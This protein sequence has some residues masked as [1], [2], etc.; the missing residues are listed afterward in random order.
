MVL[1]L[2]EMMETVVSRF[3]Q[4]SISN[5]ELA[6]PEPQSEPSEH[7]PDPGLPAYAIDTSV[8]LTE[9]C[10][11]CAQFALAVPAHV[12]LAVSL[13]RQPHHTNP[14]QGL[15][16]GNRCNNAVFQSEVP[17]HFLNVTT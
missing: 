8:F 3:D 4:V 16:N 2:D 10:A 6:I 7:S 1:L 11:F 9:S 5:V 13:S 15:A 12:I 17:H 14:T